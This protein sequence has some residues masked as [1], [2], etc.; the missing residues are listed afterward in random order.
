MHGYQLL[1]RTA[2]CQAE[3]MWTR[4]GYNTRLHCAGKNRAVVCSEGN[5]R[6]EK[7]NGERRETGQEERRV[8]KCTVAAHIQM[9]HTQKLLKKGTAVPMNAI[10]TYKDTTVTAPLIL[11]LGTRRRRVVSCTPRPLSSPG[12]NRPGRRRTGLDRKY[13]APSG[14]QSTISRFSSLQPSQYTD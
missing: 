14:N 8:R 13:P 4:S 5:R 3:N 12:K 2:N 9:L 10:K 11:N 1:G 7:Y 6:N